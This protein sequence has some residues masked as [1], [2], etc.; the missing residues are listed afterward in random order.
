M[1]EQLEDFFNSKGIKKNVPEFTPAQEEQIQKVIQ[2]VIKPAFTTLADELSSYANFKA[3][4][5][6][7]KK[8]IN[9]IKENIELKVYRIMQA[10][11]IYR[12]KFSIEDND[13]FLTGQ[14]CKPELYGES[15]EYKYTDLKKV[16][17]DIKENDIKNDFSN[18]FTTNVDIK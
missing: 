12:P 4:I 9:S 18:A 10:K 7:S 6:T 5:M 14:F 13:I 11:F 2:N 8:S 15:V 16:I 3:D 17:A 1:T